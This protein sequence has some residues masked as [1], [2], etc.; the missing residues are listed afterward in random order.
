VP[1]PTP[2]SR[3]PRLPAGYELGAHQVFGALGGQVL[4]DVR[5]HLG[6]LLAR[7]ELRVDGPVAHG[8]C[9]VV[10]P[11]RR[12]DGA[13]AALKVGFVDEEDGVGE[14]TALAA[15]DGRG[16]AQLLAAAP[17][18]QP[19][20]VDPR[21][22]RWWTVGGLLL[23]RLDPLRD[24]HSVSESAANTVIGSL[25]RRLAV[26]VAPTAQLPTLAA[27]AARWTAELPM[28]WAQT[29]RPCPRRLVDA[30]VA[31][32]RELGGDHDPVLVHGDLHHANVLAAHRE[33]WLVIDPKGLLA[34]AAFD[35]VPMLRNRWDMIA[36]ASSPRRALEHRLAAVVDA[37]GL[38]PM[39]ARRWA[40]A[41]AVDDLLWVVVHR[42]HDDGFAEVAAAL[43]AWLA[44]PP[45]P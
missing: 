35:V 23:E 26:P 28:E 40:Q 29:G 1:E 7:W 14:A 20:T 39:R 32:C 42:R 43:A 4:A 45:A 37:A 16:A 44:E 10:V 33:P 22:G 2:A 5:R 12:A 41:R 8:L 19:R 38:D 3:P 30:A 31:T 18:L 36:A 9:A 6:D 11:V 17:E 21:N 25:L 27:L 15:W 24:L 34:E 13:A